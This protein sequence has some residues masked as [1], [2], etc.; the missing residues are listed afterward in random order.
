LSAG[1]IQDLDAYSPQRVAA[2]IT[3]GSTDASDAAIQSGYG[4][5][6]TLF[7]PGIGIQGAGAASD[8]AEFSG[9]G[10]S[11][12]APFAAGVAALYLQRHPQATPADV[13]S[14]ILSAATR[15]VVKKAGAA[16]PLLLHLVSGS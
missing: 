16:P 5:H 14:A 1:G 3:V 7:A 9:D 6:L 13:K 4:P 8:T 15:D 12:A 11:Y 2:A 10:D